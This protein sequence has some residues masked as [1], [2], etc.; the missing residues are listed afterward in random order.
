LNVTY[1]YAPHFQH[2]FGGDGLPRLNGMKVSE[3][4]PMLERGIKKIGAERDDNYWAP[5]PGNAGAAMQDLL[6]LCAL[7]ET[8]DTVQVT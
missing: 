1:N 8:D 2:C 3:V 4:M 5:T 7:C 6:T